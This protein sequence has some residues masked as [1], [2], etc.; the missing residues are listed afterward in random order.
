MTSHLLSLAGALLISACAAAQG[1]SAPYTDPS[2]P[3]RQ[4]ATDLAGRMTLGE[5]ID[6]LSGYDD[7]F[8]HPCRR[9]G[10]PAFEMADGPLGIASWGLFG[11]ATAYPSA[12]SLAA[13]WNR[14]LARDAGKAFAEDWRARGIHFMLAPGVNIYR[15]SKGARNFEYFGE[16]PWLTSEMAMPFVQAVAAGGVIPVVK[17]FVGNDQEYDRYN[18]S[19][20]VAEDALR[21]IYMLP[22]ERL[23]KE[24]KIDAIMSGYNLLNGRHCSEN[25]YLDSMLHKAWGFE[26][27]H[28]SD[29]GATHST[30]AAARAGLD[31]EMG[32]NSY[33]I[34]D[35]IMPLIERG[36]LS[37][38]D[39]DRK[40]TNIYTPCFEYGFFDRPQKID[41]LTL[42]SP[43]RNRAALEA[44]RE[45]IILLKNS[46]STLPFVP[47]EIKRIAVVGPM[48]NPSV[49]SDRR[50]RNDGINY[51]GGGSSKVNPWYIRN[52]LDGVMAA[53]PD[54]EVYY[55]EG[56]SAGLRRNAF[57]N[58]VFVAPDGSQGLLAE[59]YPTPEAIAPSV[60]RVERNL[61]NQ[62]WGQPRDVAGLTDHHRIVWRGQIVPQATDTLILFADGQGACTVRVNGETMLDRSTCQS[63]F[64]DHLS[65]PV[66]EG[67]PVDIEVDYRRAGISPGEMRLGYIASSELDFSEAE[68]IARMADAV[69]CCI[70]FD[71]SVELE[72]RDRP[73]ELP[74]GQD[75]LVERMLAANP[76]TAVVVT[77]GGAVDMS[78][79]ADSAPS[80]VHLLYP[81]MEGGTA[82]GEIISGAV[83]PSAKLPFTIERKWADSPAA[84]N[85]DETR[86][87]AKV[88]YREGLFTGYRGYD[89]SGVEPLFPFGHGLSYTLFS[90]SGLSVTPDGEGGLTVGFDVTNTGSRAGAEVSQVYIT[91]VDTESRPVRELKGFAK[92]RLEPG[93][94]RHVEIALP[95]ASLRQFDTTLHDWRPLPIAAVSVGSSSR[96]LPLVRHM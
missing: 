23:V 92:T 77:G 88:Y 35:S 59:Y 19:T 9:L 30:L 72:G 37:E 24:G 82:L 27:L 71:G 17:H 58:S 43:S 96:S 26:G 34:A 86:S 20:E 69:V 49:I 51:G 36:L 3:A 80:I 38:A 68:K 74:Y 8:L 39:I 16:D 75:M 53:Y 95:A 56:V 94:T 73:F 63:F 76:S 60:T 44:A 67:S 21:E 32:S 4:R 12:L 90:Y 66:N 29:W 45:G 85:Y 6:L 87:E 1:V 5:K 7:F 64:Y 54:A 33:F 2:L 57:A 50:H 25:Q 91:P 46:G 93:E 81:G 47:S 15:A 61:N 41:S 55:A 40:V 62:W 84:G 83:N 79:W 48:A 70:G 89:H 10:V 78:R 52:I 18:I 22:F 65:I 28:M 42:Y 13:S 11:R 31:L 14:D